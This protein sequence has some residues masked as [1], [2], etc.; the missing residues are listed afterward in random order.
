MYKLYKDCLH[1]MCSLIV[2]SWEV[3][4]KVSNAMSIRIRWKCHVPTFFHKKGLLQF[5]VRTSQC[6]IWRPPDV[7]IFP[8][9]KA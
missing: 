8:Y 4:R 2:A 1:S 9:L 3:Q 7:A 5:E 6:T